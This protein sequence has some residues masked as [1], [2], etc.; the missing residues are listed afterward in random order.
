MIGAEGKHLRH[1]PYWFQCRREAVC[2]NMKE[3]LSSNMHIGFGMDNTDIY[4][5]GLKFFKLKMIKF[6]LS[7][8]NGGY[9]SNRLKMKNMEAKRNS[10]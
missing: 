6:I 2:I 8:Y 4:M 9:I 10:I 3:A 5:D 7:M 1:E